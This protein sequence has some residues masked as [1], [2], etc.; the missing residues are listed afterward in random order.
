M[1]YL[2]V[3]NLDL[4]LASRIVIIVAAFGKVM[5]IVTV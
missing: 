5:K 4:V 3:L 1:S 2:R